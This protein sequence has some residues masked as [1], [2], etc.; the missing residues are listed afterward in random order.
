MADESTWPVS[1]YGRKI[2]NELLGDLHGR[3]LQFDVTSMALN[4]KGVS[5]PTGGVI[6]YELPK[7]N[8]S[9]FLGYQY[10]FFSKT[11][12]E[13]DVGVALRK[14]WGEFRFGLFAGL[15]S[16][17]EAGPYE[18]NWNVGAS[19]QAIYDLVS[20]K[21]FRLGL[22][23]EAGYFGGEPNAWVSRLGVGL[24]MTTRFKVGSIW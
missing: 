8:Y 21:Y 15:P 4:V 9:L 7:D 24:V 5:F 17:T 10:A 12:H 18:D 20:T 22:M 11:P 14:S 6:S 19:V 1:P 23:G 3:T 13:F 2:Y 16:L